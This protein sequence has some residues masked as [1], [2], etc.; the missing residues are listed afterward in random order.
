[1][2]GAVSWWEW[3]ATALVGVLAGWLANRAADVLPGVGQ[4]EPPAA[5]PGR[6]RA[7]RPAALLGTMV[8]VFLLGRA[9][10]AGNL[11][12]LFAFWF[13][14]FYFLT[15]A[16]IDLEQR[17][18]LDIM[19]VPAALMALALAAG[20]GLPAVRQA[21]LGA[22]VGLGI[23]LLLALFSRGKLGAGDVKLA[24]VIGLATGYP[25]VVPALCAGIL[26]GGIATG[27]LLLSG[28]IGLKSYIAYAPYLAA[29]ALGV[30]LY[31]P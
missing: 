29:G 7:G 25:A 16:V 2:A 22:A 15:V 1:M 21:L 31:L 27:V 28:R 9:R 8:A 20:R 5:R 13:Y 14:A 23:F 17:R 11:S 19:S 12:A 30:L 3:A 10:F 26:C 6:R 24:G 18:V 4:A